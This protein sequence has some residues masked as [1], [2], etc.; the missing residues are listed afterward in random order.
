MNQ[1]TFFNE[2]EEEIKDLPLLEKLMEYAVEYENVAPVEFNVIFV[3]NNYIHRLNKEYRGL[4]RETDVITFALEDHYDIEY[5]D[6]RLLGDI[7]I[8]INQAVVQASEY[9]HSLTR[10]L[11]FLCVHGFYH[12]LGY[13]HQTKEEEKEMFKKQE[14]VLSGFGIERK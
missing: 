12:L 6:I 4:D 14:E 3:D 13:D 11:S 5:E 1:I 9:G 8:S 7:Y 2:T 10:E